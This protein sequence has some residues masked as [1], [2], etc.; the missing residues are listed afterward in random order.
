VKLKPYLNPESINWTDKEWNNSL[1]RCRFLFKLSKKYNL[2]NDIRCSLMFSLLSNIIPENFNFEETKFFIDKLILCSFKL[3]LKLSNDST[4]ILFHSK[5]IKKF[6][7]FDKIK[8]ENTKEEI[9]NIYI[10]LIKN[11]LISIGFWL[12]QINSLWIPTIWLSSILNTKGTEFDE[13]IF[14]KDFKTLKCEGKEIINTIRENLKFLIF[15]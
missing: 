12:R 15:L 1:F 10:D 5:E 9:F 13:F 3:P 14:Q 7:L 4:N 8:F 11:N 6:I 2:P